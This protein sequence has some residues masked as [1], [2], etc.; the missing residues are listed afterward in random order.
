MGI[1]RILLEDVG[2]E[3]V[4]VVKEYLEKKGNLYLDINDDYTH[5]GQGSYA[6][7]YSIR[8]YPDKV[9]RI[10]GDVYESFFIDVAGERNLKHVVRVFYSDIIEFEDNNNVEITVMEK[11]EPLTSDQVKKL[12]YFF[13][14]NDIQKKSDW[15]N[16]YKTDEEYKILRD[17]HKGVEELNML[18][19]HLND[20]HGGNIMYDPK[21][22]RYKIIDLSN[23]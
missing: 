5:I 4:E 11:L 17:I 22:K 16:L 18:G 9:I 13:K 3:L 20:L 10:E 21:T 7:V 23:T 8:E 1:T 6:D 15:I 14:N 2:Q 19:I 12:H